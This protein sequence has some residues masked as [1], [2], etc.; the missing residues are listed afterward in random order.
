RRTAQT[1]RWQIPS[2]PSRQANVINTSTKHII[3]TKL[4]QVLI[5]KRPPIQTVPPIKCRVFIKLTTIY[6]FITIVPNKS[7]TLSNCVGA[8]SQHCFLIDNKAEKDKCHR[9]Y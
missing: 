3:Y 8:M 1:L 5:I 2:A 9:D 4:R 7:K 6:V